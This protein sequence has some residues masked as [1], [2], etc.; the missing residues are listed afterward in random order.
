MVRKKRDEP[1]TPEGKTRRFP[2]GG[3]AG[4]T[5]G[6]GTRNNS[7]TKP[8]S[9]VDRPSQGYGL[10]SETRRKPPPGSIPQPKTKPEETGGGEHGN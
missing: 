9:G 3:R 7:G 5:P 8:G 6:L 10:V 1:H 4:R 2:A